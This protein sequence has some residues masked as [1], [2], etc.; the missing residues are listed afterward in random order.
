MR[1]IMLKHESNM[2]FIKN[3]FY[4]F[5]THHYEEFQEK[6]CYTFTL[7]VVGD[8]IKSKQNLRKCNKLS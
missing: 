6:F 4:I 3:M 7:M 5:Q 1:D 8:G 2:N